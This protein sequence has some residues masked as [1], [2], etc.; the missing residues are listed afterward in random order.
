MLGC[1]L[2]KPKW[3]RRVKT[4]VVAEKAH[5]MPSSLCFHLFLNKLINR[6]KKRE[7]LEKTAKPA[8]PRVKEGIIQ[9]VKLDLTFLTKY[10][11]D[12]PRY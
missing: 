5:R 10:I 4:T 11:V 2:I 12:F 8:E 7:L 3:W 6:L 9:K 1:N